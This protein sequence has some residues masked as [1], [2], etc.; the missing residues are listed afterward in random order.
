MA[1]PRRITAVV[2]QKLGDGIGICHQQREQSYVLNP[3]SA[4]MWNHCDG[5]TSRRDLAEL[6]KQKFNVPPAQ[7]KQLMQVALVELDHA[8]LLETKEPEA[9]EFSRR[10][11]IKS[12][13]A[14]GLS[15]A[16]I[17]VISSG[18]ARAHASGVS[19]DTTTPPPEPNFEFTGFLA[20][21]DN[22]P[23]VNVVKAGRAVPVK[24]SLNGPQGLDI[25]SPGYPASNVMDCDGDLPSDVIEE[26]TT[27][28]ESSLSYD[29]ATDLYTY[30]WKTES[31]WSGE[32]RVLRVKLS[33]G[34][35]YDAL[36]RFR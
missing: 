14:A 13:A 15:L 29:A 26:T 1:N 9:P 18:V 10:G 19:S 25:F 21:V 35:A 4:L 8:G 31:S 34:C 36:F 12:V 5:R 23:T 24:F 17:P 32:C 16:L 33:D 7:A 6:I 3:T 30:V 22:P 20:P 28:G 2:T 27:A 11:I